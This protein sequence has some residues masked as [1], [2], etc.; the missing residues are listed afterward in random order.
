MT[1]GRIG[2]GDGTLQLV[3]ARLVVAEA[4]VGTPAL[5]K[6]RDVHCRAGELAKSGDR[7]GAAVG[8]KARAT[9]TGETAAYTCT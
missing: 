6:L 3:R 8:T 1:R 4:R 7:V 9:G 5:Q 2:A